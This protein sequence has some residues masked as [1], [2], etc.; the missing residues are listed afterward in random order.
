[1]GYRR[2]CLKIES[3]FEREE[4]AQSWGMYREQQLKAQKEVRGWEGSVTRRVEP[5]AFYSWI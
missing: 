4:A 3:I 2:P 1:M 5:I